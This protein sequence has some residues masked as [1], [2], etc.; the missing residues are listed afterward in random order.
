[1]IK[2]I[3]ALFV[4]LLLSFSGSTQDDINN[5][6]EMNA[7]NDI[8]SKTAVLQDTNLPK[9]FPRPSNPPD[10]KQE[11]ESENNPKNIQVNN[12]E[13]EP[14]QI[15]VSFAGDCTIGTD[16]SFSYVNSFPYR[17][18][19]VGRDYSYFFKG[20]QSIFQNDDLTLVNLE[21]TLTTEKK[22][23][24]KTF[25]F[26]G[27]PSYVSIL[28]EGGIDMVN[29]SNNH[30]YDY[31]KQGFDETLEVLEKAGVKYSGEGHIAY[32]EANG[33][34]IASIGYNGWSTGIQKALGKDI[35]AAREKADLVIV[36]FH[37]G[38]ERSYYP[39]STQITLG[40]Y[41]IDQGADLVVG[42]H[43]H[44]VQGIDKYKGKYIVYSL[45]NF[46][47]GGNR[48]PADKDTFVFQNRFVFQDGKLAEN[49]GIVHACRLS[50]VKTVNDYQPALLTGKDRERVVDRILQ[51]SSKLKYGIT[52]DDVVFGE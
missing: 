10:V 28:T 1:M 51:Y 20:V 3:I 11:D 6:D 13:N 2:R 47:F 36:S 27:D 42:H 26:K 16:E 50:S 12:P 35:A 30:I 39:N 32:Q 48:N 45:G 23:A 41:A 37:W 31:L 52:K 19:K 46:C 44:V 5:S 9:P 38:I 43:P 34:N 17:F 4:V 15:L 7:S 8:S 24:Q 40:R 21:T 25:R 29:I 33:I 22:K 18:E 49:Q 14:V